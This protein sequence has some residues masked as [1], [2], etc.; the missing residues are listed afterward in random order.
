MRTYYDTEGFSAF[1]PQKDRADTKK[2][3][4]GPRNPQVRAAFCLPLLSF[5]GTKG[6]DT[7]V[8]NMNRSG[9][10]SSRL[11][12]SAQRELAGICRRVKRS[13]ASLTGV[14]SHV[15]RYALFATVLNPPP[16]DLVTRKCPR[17]GTKAVTAG[18]LVTREGAAMEVALRLLPSCYPEGTMHAFLEYGFGYADTIVH[19]LCRA[20]LAEREE[21]FESV[22]TRTAYDL[23][24]SLAERFEK[25]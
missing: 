11:C 18:P 24:P 9:W 1:K 16:L 25:G 20:S 22:I 5:S 2:L 21:V 7:E 23:R 13:H 12:P 15:L 4:K 14:E 19:L 10:L 3:S 17:G 8:L 6:L